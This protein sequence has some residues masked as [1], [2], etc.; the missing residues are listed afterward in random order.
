MFVN[1]AL[2]RYETLMVFLL[3]FLECQNVVHYIFIAKSFETV[4]FW[5]AKA[6]KIIKILDLLRNAEVSNIFVKF[7]GIG[8]KITKSMFSLQEKH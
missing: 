8:K 7:Q 6:T 2:F 4:K 1:Q 3:D 5:A